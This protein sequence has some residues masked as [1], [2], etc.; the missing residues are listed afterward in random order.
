MKTIKVSDDMKQR[1]ELKSSE[2]GIPIGRLTDEL[3][4]FGLDNYD[5]TENVVLSDSFEDLIDI[6]DCPKR[7]NAV[8]IRDNIRE[9]GL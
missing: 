6:I 8:Q 2:T 9:R 7:T 3:L 1:L 5:P 4:S